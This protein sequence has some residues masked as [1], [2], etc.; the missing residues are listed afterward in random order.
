LDIHPDVAG[1]NRDRERLGW[2]NARVELA[3]DEQTPD[4]PEGHPADEIG[5]VD[6]PVSQGAA[7]AIR[8]GYLRFEGDDALEAWHEFPHDF[9]HYRGIH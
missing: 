3:I 5:H 7:L 2:R 9:L 4:V 6:T 1:V 8:L